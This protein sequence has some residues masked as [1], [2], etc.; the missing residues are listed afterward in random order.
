[1]VE[2]LGTYVCDIIKLFFCLSKTCTMW[3]WKNWNIYD[4][5]LFLPY[6]HFS[7]LLVPN[8]TLW[9]F[10]EILM[11]LSCV[12]VSSTNAFRNI[13]SNSS[14]KTL[15]N[16]MRCCFFYCFKFAPNYLL[17]IEACMME[18]LKKSCKKFIG[19]SI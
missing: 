10:K 9:I 4:F 5:S 19:I 12:K 17:P 15:G 1:M 3:W 16:Y 18:L 11:F 6:M 8:A 7:W 13:E 2:A 14:I